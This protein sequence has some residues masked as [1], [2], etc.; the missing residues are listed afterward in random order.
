MKNYTVILRLESFAILLFLLILYH[1]FELSW[2]TFFIFIFAPDIS[3]IAYLRNPKIGAIVYNFVH[4]YILPFIFIVIAMATNSLFAAT[5]AAVWAIHIA[6]DRTLGFG[7]KDT[8]GFKYTH[9]GKLKGKAK[10]VE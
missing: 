4:S 1:N 7:L 8:K 3:M 6:A 5:L 2:S 10:D 9:V